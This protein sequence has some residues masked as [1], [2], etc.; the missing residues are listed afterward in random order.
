[1]TQEQQDWIMKMVN[2][3]HLHLLHKSIGGNVRVYRHIDRMGKYRDIAVDVVNKKIKG[4]RRKNETHGIGK[5]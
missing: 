4:I 5:G 2:R 1:M 3:Y